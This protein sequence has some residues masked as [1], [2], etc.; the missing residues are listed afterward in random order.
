MHTGSAPDVSSLQHKKIPVPKKKSAIFAGLRGTIVFCG[1][2]QKIA[3][4]TGVP[5]AQDS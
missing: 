3:R 4:A 5:C 2:A 1:V